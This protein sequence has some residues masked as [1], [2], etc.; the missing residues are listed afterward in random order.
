V[1]TFLRKE[2]LEPGKSFGWQRTLND[3]SYGNVQ[4]RSEPD[5]IVLSYR[6]WS[7]SED[8]QSKQYRADRFPKERTHRQNHQTRW[9]LSGYI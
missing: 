7:R 9:W 1:D 4:I 5:R 6:H 2:C 3:K 8:W